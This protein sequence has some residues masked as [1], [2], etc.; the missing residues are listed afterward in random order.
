MEQKRKAEEGA[1]VAVKRPKHHELVAASNQQGAVTQAVSFALALA[2]ICSLLLVLVVTVL[3][4]SKEIW[5]M[6]PVDLCVC[7]CSYNSYNTL[8]E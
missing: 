4:Q 5:R 3:C 6:F 2:A 7:M 8:W 1:L